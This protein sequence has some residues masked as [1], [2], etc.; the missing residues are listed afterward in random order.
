VGTGN[1][2]YTGD[3]GPATSATLYGPVGV[4]VDA[5]GDL[6][7]SDQGNDVIRKV[8]NG[9]ISTFAGTGVF[10]FAGDGG[11]ASKA[12]FDNPASIGLDS[13][14]DLYIP[15]AANQRIRVVLTNGIIY[16][17]AGNGVQGYGGDGGP[18]TS[19]ALAGPRSA[20]VAPNG[21]IYI[22]DFDNNRVRMLTPVVGANVPV[23]FNGGIV[24]ADQF[25]EFAA[26]AQGTFIEIY[27]TNL[28]TATRPWELSDFTGTSAPTQ[29]NGTSVSVNGQPGFVSYIS[30]GQ[31]N[32]QVPTDIPT[33]ILILQVNSP[34]GKSADYE[35]VV[36]A[37]EPGLYAPQSYKINGLQYVAGFD[38][39]N[40]GALALPAN[41]VAGVD[42]QPASPNDVI[43][44]Y[45]LGFGPVTPAVPA[46]QVSQGLTSLPS[47]SISIGGVDAQVQYAGLAPNYV[48]L[49][50]FN[51]VVPSIPANNAAP[52]T[53]TVNGTA[54]TQM[55][56]MAVN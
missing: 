38:N 21:N 40:N 32:V 14:G 50:Q 42:T 17:V 56:Y 15:D 26:L 5:S 25:G 35:V 51:V 3:G 49:Y 6:Y 39:N 29:L 16:T 47:F 8:T 30:P 2:N 54:G 27:G 37:I 31:V 1:A 33:G 23:I 45:G 43:T 13:A 20:S 24:T 7:I 48:G 52:V 41:S 10:G 34:G 53:F 12:E 55:L 9:I 28:A 4:Q 44:L 46:G 18:A 11:P 19:A 22:G 36:N